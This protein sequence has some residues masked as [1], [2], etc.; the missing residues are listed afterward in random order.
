MITV[1]HVELYDIFQN[2]GLVSAKLYNFVDISF[3]ITT[4]LQI[5]IF[6]NPL[7]SGFV[8]FYYELHERIKRRLPLGQ[9]LKIPLDLR[10][11]QTCY[12]LVLPLA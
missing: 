9:T 4:I 10:A 2:S 12:C 8:L 1:V 5:V 11:S 6:H 3:Y 7:L